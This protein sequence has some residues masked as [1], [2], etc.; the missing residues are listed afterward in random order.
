M[1]EI[2]ITTGKGSEW[3][4]GKI[5]LKDRL[6]FNLE[7]TLRLKAFCL[8]FGPGEW[9]DQAINLSKQEQDNCEKKAIRKAESEVLKAKQFLKNNYPVRYKWAYYK[10]ILKNPLKTLIAKW[11]LRSK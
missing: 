5:Q 3:F 4:L 10:V 6:W 7:G 11:L 9:I 1:T 2:E 8:Q